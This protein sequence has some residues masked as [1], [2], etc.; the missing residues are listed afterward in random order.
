MPFR[1]FCFLLA[2]FWITLPAQSQQQQARFTYLTTNQGLSQNNVTCI[3]QDRK[4]FMWFGTRDGLNKY[5]GYSYTLYRNDPLKS[6]SLSHSYVHSLFEDKQGQLW[7]GTDDGGLNLFDPDTETFTSYKHLLGHPNSLSHN[8]VMA[9]AQDAGGD[10]WVGTAGGGLDRF[11]PQHKTFTHFSHQNSNAASLSHNEVSSILIDRAGIVWAG[12][13]GG[14]LNRLDPKTKSFTHYIHNSADP[15][16]LSQNRV[17]SCFE[18]SQ[19]RFWVATEGGLNQFDRANGIFKRFQ[20]TTGLP[21]QLSHNDVK[22]LA[23]DNDHTLWIGTQNGGINLL[24]P[25]GTFSYYTYQVDNNQGLNSGSIYSIYR[26]RMGTMWVG[27]YSGG[28]NKLDAAPLKFKLYQRTRINTNKLTNNNILA[29]REDDRGDLWL[30]TDGGGINVLKKSKSV[31]MAY[32]DTS[33]YAATIGSNFVLTIYEDRKKR[34]WTGNYKGGLTLF[35]RSKGT[36]ESKGKLSPLSISAILEARNGIMWLGTFEEGLIRYDQ[37]TGAITRYQPNA[38]QAGKLNYPTITSLWEDR[39]GNIW[40]GTDGGGVN[41]FHP[42]KNKFTQYLH[43]DPIPRSL[44]SNQVNIL[45]ESSTGQLWLGTNAGLNQ[46]DAHTQT[47]RTY[48]LRDGLA[49][50]VIQGILEDQH[51]ILWLSTNKGLSAFNP[52]THTIR[53]FDASDGL[54]ESSFNR[55]ACYKSRTGQLFFGGLSG[56]NSFYPDSLRYNSFIPPVYITDFQLFNQSVHMQDAESVLKKPISETH[57]I[58]LSYHQSVL[59]FGFAA[60]SYTVSSKNQYAYK[61]EGFDSDWIQ[62]GTQRTATYTNLD[63]GDYVFRVKAANNDGVWNETGT[64]VNLHIIPPF[65]QTNWFRVL[66]ALFVVGGLYWVYWLRVNRIQTQ[67]MVLQHQV[68]ARTSEVLQQRQ[69]LQEQAFHVQL[70]QAKVEQQEAQQQLQESEQRFREIAE[71]VDEVFWIHSANP[72]QLLYVNPAFERVWGTTFQRSHEDP[73]SF[74]ETVLPEDRPAVLAFIDQYKA[75]IDGELY[76]RLQL[77]NKPLRWLLIRTF[78]IR[79]EAGKVVRHIGIA[80]DVTSQK[81]KELVLQQSLLREQELNQLKSQFVSTASHE[82]RT[83]LATIQSSVELIKLY[84]DTPAANGRPAIQKHLGVI[85]KQVDQFT[86]LLTDVLTIGQ[87]EAGK[88]AYAP[89]SEDIVSLCEILIDTHFSGRSDRRNVQLT[90]EGVPCRVDL[91]ATLISHVLINLLSNAF[92]FSTNTPPVLCIQFKPDSLVL[93]V[94]DTGMGIPA[95]DQASLFQA[96]F[97]ASNTAGIQGTGLGLVIARQFVERHGGQLTVKSQE[98]KGTTFTVNLP[99]GCP[100]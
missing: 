93:Q 26:D 28:V 13:L 88:V 66:V 79:D 96:F 11:D 89:Q 35:N 38:G 72:F 1:F 53:N 8:K 82:F 40:L 12:T 75:G 78:I 99:I 91:D 50:E 76:Y 22:A 16:S 74:M 95:R 84:L 83:P 46:Y 30:G 47:F 63:P 94:I 48:H 17:T 41:V 42:D 23:E 59:S 52:K 58:T 29:V 97:R 100:V 61:L 3:L 43:K 54:Q 51:G 62:A 6:T 7:I 9:I 2:G 33:R 80:N 44:S 24:H 10:L 90:I 5:D 34:I 98:G 20:Q 68:Q 64:F 21:A 45:F 39:L 70:L 18:D 37:N 25:D 15:H 77:K 60:L 31:F 87:I 14:G 57:D 81:D 73:L 71:N 19:G 4:G 67:K 27:T 69:E 65:W 32:Q 49:N 86:T 36:F 85:E 92:K 55:M 56:L